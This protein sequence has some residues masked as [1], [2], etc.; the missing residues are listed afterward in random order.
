MGD[1]PSEREGAAQEDEE[2]DEYASPS[3]D[4]DPS[5]RDRGE[6][7]QGVVFKTAADNMRWRRWVDRVGRDLTS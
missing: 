1:L 3:S 7:A 5:W 2:G 6:S 4:E